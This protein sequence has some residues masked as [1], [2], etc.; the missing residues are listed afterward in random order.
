MR[1]HVIA[2]NAVEMGFFGYAF[3]GETGGLSGCIHII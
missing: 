1:V 3:G 2:F